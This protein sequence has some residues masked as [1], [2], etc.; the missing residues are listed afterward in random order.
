MEL[1]LL[2]MRQQIV[3]FGTKLS[4]DGTCQ[5]ACIWGRDGGACL[6]QWD[7]AFCVPSSPHPPEEKKTSGEGLVNCTLHLIRLLSLPVLEFRKSMVFFCFAKLCVNFWL[8]LTGVNE[9]G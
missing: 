2:F 5:R 8:R 4:L 9:S 7:L 6:L 3:L 1:D